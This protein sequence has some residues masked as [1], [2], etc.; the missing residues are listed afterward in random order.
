MNRNLKF[1]IAAA[2]ASLGVT[3]QAHAL[4]ASTSTASGSLFLYAFDDRTI[5]G[6]STATNSAIFDLGLASAFDA[7]KN[8]TF[9]FSTNS[10]WTSYISTIAN[11]ANVKWGVYGV[12]KGTGAA[13]GSSLITTLSVVPASIGGF[14][15]GSS[16]VNY[17]TEIS[18][19]GPTASSGSSGFN[20]VTTNDL[21]TG[22]WA[23]NA[24]IIPG[25]LT[26]GLGGS[27][28]FFKY[29][30]TGSKATSLAT[31]T[32]YATG[33]DADYFTLSNTGVLTYTAV[34]SVPE[35]DSYAM[36]LAGLGLVGYMVRRR[37]AA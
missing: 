1:A 23:N 30:S 21:A 15:F 9:D 26:A 18:V 12:T 24:G 11:P 2:I 37:K 33:G 5:I 8:Q 4:T 13:T 17:N 10:A 25:T 28:D 16:I 36:M 14:A 19:Y 20:A 7:T 31:K 29:T 32:A 34:A 35:A 3:S 6:N 22:T 27:M